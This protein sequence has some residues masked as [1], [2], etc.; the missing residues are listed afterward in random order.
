[1][2]PKESDMKSEME[3][4]KKSFEL[5][6]K[7]IEKHP[8]NFI[9][10]FDLQGRLYYHLCNEFQSDYYR[11]H[12]EYKPHV[13]YDKNKYLMGQT[14]CIKKY[15]PKSIQNKMTSSHPIEIGGILNV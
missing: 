3:K 7:D 11:I 8:L 15:V 1:M 6:K 13:K 2:K 9:S 5:L 4:V 12:L 10:E 14:E